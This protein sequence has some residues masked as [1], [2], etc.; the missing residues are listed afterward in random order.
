MKIIY[1]RFSV[2]LILVVWKWP[3]YCLV[4]VPTAPLGSRIRMRE[5]TTPWSHINVT[6]CKSTLNKAF[7]NIIKLIFDQYYTVAISAAPG[8][9]QQQLTNSWLIQTQIT[10]VLQQQ[11]LLK[12]SK[13]SLLPKTSQDISLIPF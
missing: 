1:P 4:A 6:P 10:G 7:S 2:H 9:G 8:A 13:G 11:N 5:F 12:S 3:V